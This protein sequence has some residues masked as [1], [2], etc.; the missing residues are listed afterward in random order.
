MLLFQAICAPL[1]GLLNS[2]VY[3][4]TRK[5]FISA[6]CRTESRRGSLYGGTPYRNYDFVEQPS[7]EDSTEV[8][9]T[10]TQLANSCRTTTPLPW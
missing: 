3:G 2:L 10:E 8:E 5:S 1:Q 4:W 6:G 9:D 7:F